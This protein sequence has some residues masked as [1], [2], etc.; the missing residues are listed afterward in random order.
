VQKPS[1]LLDWSWL[2]LLLCSHVQQ[3]LLQQLVGFP[4]NKTLCAGKAFNHHEVHE[5]VETSMR[6]LET[7]EAAYRERLEI[8]HGDT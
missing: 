5:E 7:L 8:E 4:A 2:A 6:G 1:L 3:L